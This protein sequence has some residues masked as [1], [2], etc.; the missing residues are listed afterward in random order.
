MRGETYPRDVMTNLPNLDLR[1]CEM[2]Y[3]IEDPWAESL[4]RVGVHPGELFQE[5]LFKP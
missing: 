5:A 4:F 2:I 1:T 3:C